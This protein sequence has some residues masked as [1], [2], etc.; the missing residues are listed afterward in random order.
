MTWPVERYSAMSL[1]VSDA[2]VRVMRPELLD[3]D[4]HWHDYYELSLVTAGEAEHVVNGRARSLARGHAF[5][6]SPADF[7]ELRVR[8]AEPLECYNVVL[9]P[10]LVEP[11]LAL[12]TN[13]VDGFALPW[14]A[15][16]F[17]DAAPELQRLERELEEPLL[18]SR[19]AVE[20][21]VA[22]LLVELARRSDTP[23][24]SRAPRVDDPDLHAAVLMVDR[25]FREP[26]RLAD[27]AAHA[28]LSPNY[29][30]ER[31]RAYTGTSFQVYL[32]ERRLRFAQSLLTATT[33][34][35]TEVCHAAGF[36]SLSH[37]GRAYRR[38]FGASP[39]T[40]TRRPASVTT[41]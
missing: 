23:A 22:A 21:L 4:V 27:V 34:S 17:A 10:A 41:G 8:R 2:G 38:R 28:H 20:A 40:A 13:P 11:H 39:S 18:G 15:E 14:H 7:H 25:H 32:Q 26:L 36:N 30:S 5:L 24:E 19:V 31:F 1:V 3:V 12:L 16:D 33:L 6:L 29:F 37:F 9:E 35:V